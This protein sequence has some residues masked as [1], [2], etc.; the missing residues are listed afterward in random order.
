MSAGILTPP[1]T[2]DYIE[3]V[4][5]AGRRAAKSIDEYLTTGLW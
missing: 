1:T 2:G 5:G 3:Q 4:M